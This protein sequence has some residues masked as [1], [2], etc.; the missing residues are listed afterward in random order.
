MTFNETKSNYILCD[1]QVLLCTVN[2]EDKITVILKLNVRKQI[3]GSYKLAKLELKFSNLIEFNMFEDFSSENYSDIIFVELESG[4][5]YLSLDPYG[6]SNEPN[7]NDN[8]VIKAKSV[9]IIEM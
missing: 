2:F 3:G 7:E 1:G 6:N 4:V 5:Y 8:F 9:E